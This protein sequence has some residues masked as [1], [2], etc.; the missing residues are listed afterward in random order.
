MQIVPQQQQNPPT[1]ARRPIQPSTHGI[2][3]GQDNPCGG[4]QRIAFRQ[5]PNSPF[6][7]SGIRI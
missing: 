6:K 2:F 5:R 4:T 1:L 7:T 3:V